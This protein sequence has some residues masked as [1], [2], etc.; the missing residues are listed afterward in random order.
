MKGIQQEET[1]RTEKIDLRAP[2]FLG[3]HRIQPLVEKALALEIA[4]NCFS[5]SS[6]TSCSHFKNGWTVIS[7]KKD[8]KV[9]FP[10]EHK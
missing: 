6:V 7:K 3:E 10:F 1:E 4:V 8:W 9:I 5:V 2:F